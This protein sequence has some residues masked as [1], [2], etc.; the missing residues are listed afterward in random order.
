MQPVNP[1]FVAFHT[2]ATIAILAA[3]VLISP[4]HLIWFIL[5]LLL[6]AISN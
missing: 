2:I 3:A 4:A 1:A 5:L 6:L